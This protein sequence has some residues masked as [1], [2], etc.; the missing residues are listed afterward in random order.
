MRSFLLIIIVLG[1][2]IS[3]NPKKTEEIKAREK[4]LSEKEKA[5][6]L[7]TADYE[8]LKKM[9][10]SLQ[11]IQNTP[12]IAPVLPENLLGKWVSKMVCTESD[13]KEH[14][15]GDQRTD[16]FE[17][18]KNNSQL[19]AKISNKT[20]S[21]RIYT[22]SYDGESIKLTYQSDSTAVN[23][24]KT[25]FIF[26]D[27]ESERISGIRETTGKEDCVAKFTVELVRS[28]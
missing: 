14:V 4:I 19:S 24:T 12:E 28:K 9:R 26:K 1:I 18:F 15:I 27:L 5:F 17:I 20:G 22:G 25:V 3:C 7:K 21:S 23:P 6:E 11:E 16:D 2:S 10:D 8:A 13:C